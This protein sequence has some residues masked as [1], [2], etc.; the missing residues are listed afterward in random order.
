MYLKRVNK[1][2]KIIIKKAGKFITT[3][4]NLLELPIPI[5]IFGK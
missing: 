3:W 4:K 5:L 1:A 2:I